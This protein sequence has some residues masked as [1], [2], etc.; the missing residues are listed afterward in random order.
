MLEKVIKRYPKS[1]MSNTKWRKI[2]GVVNR[3]SLDLGMC[4]WKLVS[5]TTSVAGF[6]PTLGKIGESFVGDCGALNGC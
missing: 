6:L 5:D 2:F 1:F 4:I 3:Q